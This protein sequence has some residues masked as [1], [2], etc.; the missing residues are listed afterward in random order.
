MRTM[1]QA[2]SSITAGRR[3]VT[4]SKAGPAPK[5]EDGEP[6]RSRVGRLT[7]RQEEGE[8]PR[9][10]D[11]GSKAA[12]REGAEPRSDPASATDR[13]S[14]PGEQMA[15]RARAAKGGRPGAGPGVEF[16]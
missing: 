16:C 5:E 14:R 9:Q 3:E 7:K 11:M 6:A 1:G 10:A 2:A 15:Q 8:G 12:N 13:G 4:A